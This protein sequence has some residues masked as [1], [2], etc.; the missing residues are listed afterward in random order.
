MLVLLKLFRC[1]VFYHISVH[2]VIFKPAN[3]Y[4]RAQMLAEDEGNN[5]GSCDKNRAWCRQIFGIRKTKMK[6]KTNFQG[7][8]KNVQADILSIFRI[9][10]VLRVM[11]DKFIIVWIIRHGYDA[12]KVFKDSLTEAIIGHNVFEVR[13]I[14]ARQNLARFGC[15]VT[16]SHK[17]IKVS[18]RGFEALGRRIPLHATQGDAV[19]SDLAAQG[20]EVRRR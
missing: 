18:L 12:V 10:K 8:V 6:S 1:S 17:Q 4:P 7:I 20:G 15:V 5:N 14:D 9:R 19:A 3:R 11:F 2:Y 13:P 16:L